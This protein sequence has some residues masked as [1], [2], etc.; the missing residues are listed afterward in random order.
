MNLR[1]IWRSKPF[2]CN[3]PSKLA[4][5]TISF[6]Q[7]IEFWMSILYFSSYENSKFDKMMGKNHTSNFR[8]SL[9]REVFGL[10]KLIVDSITKKCF[11]LSPFISLI[12]LLRDVKTK[13]TLKWSKSGQIYCRAIFTKFFLQNCR[14]T[15]WIFKCRN[16]NWSLK[17]TQRWS[18][19]G[20][21]R[22]N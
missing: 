19:L 5:F 4:V 12:H 14:T 1:S 21:A 11:R 6:C 9:H 10:R 20:H 16:I 3:N 15:V 7:F 2:L 22:E 13:Y 18:G 17:D 8:R